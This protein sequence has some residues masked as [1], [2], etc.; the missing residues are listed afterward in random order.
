M[1]ELVNGA[2]EAYTEPT[3]EADLAAVAV[4][5]TVELDASLTGA[6]NLTEFNSN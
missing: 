4:A 1:S 5:S 2:Y 3:Q 6:V